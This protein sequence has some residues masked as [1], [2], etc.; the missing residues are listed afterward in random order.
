MENEGYHKFSVGLLWGGVPDLETKI[1]RDKAKKLL[2]GGGIFLRNCYSFNFSEET[3]FWYLVKDSFGGMEELSSNTRNQIRKSLKTYYVRKITNEELLKQ[4]FEAYRLSYLNYGYKSL[5]SHE[6]F[7]NFI[8][9]CSS[10]IY[11]FWGVFYVKTEN[12]VGFAINFIIGNYCNY[13]TLKCIPEHQKNYAYYS[14]IY[15]MNK[16]YLAD[17]KLRYV[18]DGAR[19]ITSH[20]GI[21]PFLEQ[22]FKFKKMYCSMNV[23]Y[24]SWFGTLIKILFPF[25]KLIKHPKVSAILRQEAWARGLER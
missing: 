14:L 17:R 25:R 3:Q 23:Y 20:S 21:Q 7:S 15:E 8:K 5:P 11:E 4:G 2:S 12:M 16:Y 13:Q 6:S 22:K 18:C 19:S 10:D 9:L 1:T 24:K